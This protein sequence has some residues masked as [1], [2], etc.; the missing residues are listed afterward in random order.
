MFILLFFQSYNEFLK[1]YS[2]RLARSQY[3]EAYNSH[4][5]YDAVWTL[6]FALDRVV[7][8]DGEVT[9]KCLNAKIQDSFGNWSYFRNATT[10]CL[11]YEELLKTDFEGLSVYIPYCVSQ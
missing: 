4:L 2:Y 6:A 5:A 10:A 7:K 11:V 8:L 3:I 9:A 1:E